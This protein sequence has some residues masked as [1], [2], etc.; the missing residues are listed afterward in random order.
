MS[1]S[2]DSLHRLAKRF[3]LLQRK[4]VLAAT[5]GRIAGFS[6]KWLQKQ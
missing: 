2:I 6:K 5:V 1:L 4:E 3:P